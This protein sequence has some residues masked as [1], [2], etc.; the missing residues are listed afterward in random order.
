VY[1]YPH[2][3]GAASITGGVF[4]NHCSW[5]APWAGRYWFADYDMQFHTVWTITPDP[6]TGRRQIV[7][8][9]RE[10]VLTDAG[11]VVH[12]FNGPDGAVYMVNINSGEIW[13]VAPK[14]P[15][16]CAPP[17]AGF[18]PDATEPPDT[19]A[20][21]PDATAQ[22]DAAPA[23]DSGL[24]AAD[25]G[26]APRP[27]S[28]AAGTDATSADGSSTGMAKSG[29]GCSTASPGAAI[30]MLVLGAALGLTRRR[31]Q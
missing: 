1:E 24:S 20:T 29:C 28:G 30:S 25:T 13:R 5:P 9:S 6:A 3:G 21:Q 26:V 23:S 18:A 8:N 16:V 11:G 15:V 22:E 27:D 14:N 19:G 10:D 2:N 31:R 17:D 4:S 12:F 7:A